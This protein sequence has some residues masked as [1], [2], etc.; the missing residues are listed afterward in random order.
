MEKNISIILPVYNAESGLFRC[1]KSLTAQSFKNIEIICIN[2]SSSDK[3]LDILENFKRKDSRIKI[4]NKMNEGYGNAC[5]I[6]LNVAEGEYVSIIEAFDFTHK[7]MFENLF[8]LAQKSEADI[9]KSPYYKFEDNVKTAKGGFCARNIEGKRVEWSKR[10][11]I[12]NWFFRINECPSFLSF[13]PAIFSS[14]FRKSFLNSNSIRFVEARGQNTFVDM[15]FYIET[16]LLARKIVYTDNPYYYHRY[17][18]FDSKNPEDYILPFDRVE[19]TF[20]ILQRQKIKDKNITANIYK[21]ALKII[22]KIISAINKDEEFN[23]KNMPYELQLRVEKIIA[24]MDEDIINNSL[25]IDD[26]ERRLFNL[27]A[28]VSKGI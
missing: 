9:V 7:K 1:L 4:I 20:R 24:M 23:I 26:Y 13:H 22:N 14:L 5:N 27:L 2:N 8:K 11:K 18:T 3:S 25:F 21:K 15:P 16:M 19:E 12:P 6:G 10:C 28:P 17:K